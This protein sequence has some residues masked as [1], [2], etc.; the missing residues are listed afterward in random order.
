MMTLAWQADRGLA[1][2]IVQWTD[3]AER[4]RR[5]LVVKAAWSIPDGSSS[6]APPLASG[7]IEAPALQARDKVP[8]KVQADVIIVG[9]APPRSGTRLVRVGLARG[10]EVRFA[11][12]RI[13][14]ANAPIVEERAPPSDRRV[15]DDSDPAT[16]PPASTCASFK[17]HRSPTRRGSRW[18]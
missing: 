14:T 11:A 4:G 3:P 2:D 5:T 8:W 6:A 18:G 7:E 15:M 9:V 16:C 17:R 10:A 12:E 1:Y 13:A